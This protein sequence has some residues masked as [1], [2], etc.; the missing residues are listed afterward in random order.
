MNWFSLSRNIFGRFMWTFLWAAASMRT[1]HRRRGIVPTSLHCTSSDMSGIEEFLQLKKTFQ[2]TGPFTELQKAPFLVWRHRRAYDLCSTPINN[3]RHRD[4]DQ[5]RQYH[6]ASL[7]LNVT[8]SNPRIYIY[9]YWFIYLYMCVCTAYNGKCWKF[10][11]II[12]SV[13]AT[14][15]L[16]LLSKWGCA[17]KGPDGKGGVL[18]TVYLFHWI[19]IFV[20]W[21]MRL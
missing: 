3:L 16:T 9:I 6:T 18:Q 12:R 5:S 20:K 21:W 19:P 4:A 13:S 1:A 2:W 11:F 17:N 15:W 8:C 7:Q 14:Q 10:Q